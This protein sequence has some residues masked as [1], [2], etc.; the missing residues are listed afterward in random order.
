MTKTNQ[1]WFGGSRKNGHYIFWPGCL[2]DM[3]LQVIYLFIDLSINLI[4]DSELSL[5]SWGTKNIS[6][7]S[8]IWSTKVVHTFLTDPLIALDHSFPYFHPFFWFILTNYFLKD[9]VVQWLRLL[10]MDWMIVS[11]NPDLSSHNLTVFQS[12]ALLAILKVTLFLLSH[13]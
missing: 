10:N 12:R 6:K 2:N 3:D 7:G 4:S 9:S 11:S 8:Q 1:V 13:L 5:L